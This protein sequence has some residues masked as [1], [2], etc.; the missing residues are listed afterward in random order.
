[1]LGCNVCHL[2]LDVVL[3]ELFPTHLS[4]KHQ[5]ITMRVTLSVALLEIC[6]NCFRLPSSSPANALIRNLFLSDEHLCRTIL[7]LCCVDSNHMDESASSSVVFAQLLSRQ[8]TLAFTTMESLLA[9]AQ[10]V[11]NSKIEELLISRTDGSE[12][13]GC[14]VLRAVSG[15][16][17]NQSDSTLPSHAIRLLRRLCYFKSISLHAT[18]GSHVYPLRN[19]LLKKMKD[20]RNYKDLQIV[21][22][23]LLATIAEYQPSLLEI[24]IDLTE[25]KEHKGEKQIGENSC[26]PSVLAMLDEKEDQL[27]LSKMESAFRFFHALWAGK[28]DSHKYFKVLRILRAKEHFWESIFLPFY[29]DADEESILS[30]SVTVMVLAHA[31]AIIS[32]EYYYS[33]KPHKSYDKSLKLLIDENKLLSW[34][35]LTHQAT[36]RL[37]ELNPSNAFVDDKEA[38][39]SLIESWRCLWC[40]LSTDKQLVKPAQKVEFVLQGVQSGAAVLNCLLRKIDLGEECSD[41]LNVALL[42][43]SASLSTASK[44]MKEIS[45]KNLRD[46][47]NTAVGGSVSAFYSLELP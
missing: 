13:V 28:R 7:S 1:M 10:L 45:P 43:S 11:T 31:M 24:F 23:E 18:L 37:I 27:N 9:Q 46:M 20:D 2:S 22:I 42:F 41:V 3:V 21:I 36:L 47:L 40:V 15:F 8:V 5:S 29:M 25:D 17:F 26:L 34:C 4:W 33:Q 38:L 14:C 39:V 16:I 35:K 19:S 6:S 44:V 30:S 12:S 32:H